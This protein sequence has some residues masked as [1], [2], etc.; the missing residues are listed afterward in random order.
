MAHFRLTPKKR[1]RE[2]RVLTTYTTCMY[3]PQT[4][5]PAGTKDVPVGEPLAVLVYNEKDVNAFNHLAPYRPAAAE[6]G[7][8]DGP[9]GPADGTALLKFLHKLVRGG[10]IKDK[11]TCLRA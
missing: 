7:D 10:Q 5:V 11:G 9:V 4:V 8:G 1:P 3:N 2:A 6:G